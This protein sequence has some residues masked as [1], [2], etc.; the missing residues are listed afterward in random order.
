MFS[1]TAVYFCLP[2]FTHVYTQNNLVLQLEII[3]GGTSPMTKIIVCKRTLIV[4][5]LIRLSYPKND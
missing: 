1:V 3:D 4:I 5:I 2:M